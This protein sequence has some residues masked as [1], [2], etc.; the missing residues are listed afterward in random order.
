[1]VVEGPETTGNTVRGNSIR[2]NSGSGIRNDQGGNAEL[3]APAFTGASPLAGSA[4]PNCT[5]D[6][7]SDSQGEG[8]LYEGSTVADEEGNFTFDGSPSGPNITA[9][10]TDSYG[11][12]SEFSQPLRGLTS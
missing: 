8:E 4:C 3:E 10:A 12:T 6:I 9:T 7:Y 5:V 11:N 2:S 1:V